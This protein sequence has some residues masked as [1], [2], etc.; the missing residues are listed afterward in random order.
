MRALHNQLE[1]NLLKWRQHILMK[2]TEDLKA[3]ESRFSTYLQ[4]KSTKVHNDLELRQAHH[5]DL[6]KQ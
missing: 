4:N 1:A 3:A 6:M 2:Q 5:S